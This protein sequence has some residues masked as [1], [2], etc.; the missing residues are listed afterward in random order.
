M[1]PTLAQ[2]PVL[3]R[4]MAQ[5]PEPRSESTYNVFFDLVSCIVQK[6][7]D[8][9]GI[10]TFDVHSFDAFEKVLPDTQLA[11]AKYETLAAVLE[12]FRNHA[13]LPWME[14]PDMEVRAQLGSIKGVGPWTMDMILLYTLERPNVFPADDYHLKNIMAGLYGLDPNTRLKAQMLEIAE[15]WKGH[16]SL[17][18]RYL[19]AYKKL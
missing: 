3:A 15:R 17:A 6:L 12:F 18:V 19:L 14:M 16:C 7:L 10:D 8:K 9:A 5:I 11:A 4:I 2:D 1:H 13:A